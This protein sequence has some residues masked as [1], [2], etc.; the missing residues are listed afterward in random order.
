M[1]KAP[2][3]KQV[4]VTRALRAIR[5]AG[6]EVSKVEIDLKDGK[7]TIATG[8]VDEATAANAF[9]EWKTSRARPS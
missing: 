7:I 2:T 8:K 1:G 6:V 3:F 5:R 9:D 4:D